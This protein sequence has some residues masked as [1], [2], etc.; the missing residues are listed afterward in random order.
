MDGG[1]GG[2][3]EG[4][5]TVLKMLCYCLYHHCAKPITKVRDSERGGGE[6]GVGRRG[7]G[8]WRE[9]LLRSV[10]EG[11]WRG[12]RWRGSWG[13]GGALRRAVA[14]WMDPVA[15]DDMFGISGSAEAAA[16]R[17]RSQLPRLEDDGYICDQSVSGIDKS[18]IG[19][20]SEHNRDQSWGNER[21]EVG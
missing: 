11:C 19:G 14:G 17:R 3:S 12:G 18:R 10:V 5:G 7:G 2:G 8:R 4:G 1:G 13:R 21:E 16:S 6:Y 15:V 20:Q 9:V